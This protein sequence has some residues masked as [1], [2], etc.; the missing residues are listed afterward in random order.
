MNAIAQ[1]LFA[2]GSQ[3]AASQAGPNEQIE[4]MF[5]SGHGAAAAAPVFDENNY[6]VADDIPQRGLSNDVIS[7][8]PIHV[9]RGKAKL[10]ECAICKENFVSDRFY[11]PLPCGHAFHSH[12]IGQWLSRNMKCPTCRGNVAKQ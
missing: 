7:S 10:E 11:K 6:F 1:Q 8:L 2:L 3:A 12:C 4:V 5:S 9:S